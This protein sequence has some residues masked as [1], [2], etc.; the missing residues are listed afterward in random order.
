MKRIISLILA[1]ALVAA[2]PMSLTSCNGG[3][4]EYAETRDIEGRDI[5]YVEMSV[6]DFG[7]VVILLD[8]TTAPITVA[9]F[10]KLVKSGFYDGLTFHRVI[11]DFMIQG[12]DPDGNGSGGSEEEIFGEFDNNGHKNDIQHIKGVISMARSND[13]NSASSQ[14]FICNADARSSLD[15]NY[16]AFG[17]VIEGLDVIDEITETVFPKTAYA[18]YYNDTSIDPTYGM[19]KYQVWQY[20]GNGTVEKNEDKPVIE[21]I[22]VI[23]YNN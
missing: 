22:K 14:F 7:K 2:I 19:P 17:Y 3:A 20:L 21:Y 1:I 5:S 12:G 18:D 8:A 6:R 15:G 10:L 11:T 16:A 13:N 9:N 4:C 23:D